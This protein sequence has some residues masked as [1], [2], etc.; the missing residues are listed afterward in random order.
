MSSPGKVRR[1]VLEKVLSRNMLPRSL[2][3]IKPRSHLPPGLGLLKPSCRWGFFSLAVSLL[4]LL[5]KI[6]CKIPHFSGS[7]PHILRLVQHG[8]WWHLVC[9]GPAWHHHK[10]FQLFLGIT[11]EGGLHYF[12]F[13]AENLDSGQHHSAPWVAQLLRQSWESN[14]HLPGSGA[15][16]LT[17]TPCWLFHRGRTT[18][19][20][21]KM[22][23]ELLKGLL[24][25]PHHNCN[26]S[27]VF[28]ETIGDK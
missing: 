9:A 4:G 28:S 27:R 13:K 6:P 3:K 20:R 12:H 15:H 7:R 14:P 23:R 21:S 17:F 8:T 25:L 5:T 10:L 19:I 1:G 26:F 24:P 2:H 16:G 22:N 11:Q 18:F